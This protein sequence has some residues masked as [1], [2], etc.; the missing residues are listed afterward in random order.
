MK[1]KGTWSGLLDSAIESRKAYRVRCESREEAR[2]KINYLYKL[3]RSGAYTGRIQL[4][5]KGAVL[6]VIPV[7]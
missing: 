6:Y 4:R 2:G 1:E 5:R 7:A 3:L